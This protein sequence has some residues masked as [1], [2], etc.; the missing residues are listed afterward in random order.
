MNHVEDVA[1]Q[2]RKGSL[3]LAVLALLAAQPRY[4]IEIVEDL[5]SRPGLES[6]AGTIYPLLTRLRN[7]GLVDTQWRESPVGPPRK[8]Y[9]LTKIGR[10]QLAVQREAWIKLSTALAKLLKEVER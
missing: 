10:D 3:E 5:G 7:S 4:G 6:A 2:L 1:T 8:Y 9:S